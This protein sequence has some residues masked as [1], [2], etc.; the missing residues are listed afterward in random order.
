[1]VLKLSQAMDTENWFIF[2]FFFYIRF[3]LERMS[4]QNDT[5]ARWNISLADGKYCIEFEHG[6]TS[7]RRVIRVNNK[8][9]EYFFQKNLNISLIDSNFRK[10][11]E[12]I[13]CS[14]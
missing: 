4:E 6:T 7:G 9:I 13:G 5:V 1:M 3:N 11:S 12:K 10:Y 2:L 8:V 14:N